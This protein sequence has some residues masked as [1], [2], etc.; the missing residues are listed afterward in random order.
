MKIG[1]IETGK[2]ALGPMAGF[3][4]MPFRALCSEQG[5]DFTF[6][7]M[8][9]KEGIISYLDLLQKKESLLVMEKAVATSKTE[10]LVN[11]ISLY[12]ATAGNLQ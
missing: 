4:D 11:H 2:V 1:N 8:K 10:C 9:Y 12:K 6:T 3:S 7:E 5:A